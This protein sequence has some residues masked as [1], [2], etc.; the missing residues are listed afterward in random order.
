[1]IEYFSKAKR[2]VTSPADFFENEKQRNAF[3]Y[4]IKFAT[5]SLVLVGLLSAARLVFAGSPSRFNFDPPVLA[6]VS[7]VGTPVIG[8]LL[9][10]INAGLIHIFVTLWGGEN[11]YS[12][13][14]GAISYVTPIGVL[15]SAV[16]LVTSLVGTTGLTGRFIGSILGGII[17]FVL[18]IY[19]FYV[20]T[21]G[22][23]EFQDLSLGESFVAVIL[24]PIIIAVFVFTLS[25]LATAILFAQLE[26][27]R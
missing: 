11:G 20:Q 17:G 26:V 27:V 15:S 19:G 22:I 13:T 25:I 6:G 10:L 14:L 8:V 4:P 18:L 21:R 2:V 24:P 16:N 12:Q 1:V 3:G 9:L 23:S 5:F 7:V